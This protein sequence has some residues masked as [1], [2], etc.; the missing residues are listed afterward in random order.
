[1]K[2]TGSFII[3]ER[4]LPLTAEGIFCVLKAIF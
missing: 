2:G 1:M 3:N 4:S